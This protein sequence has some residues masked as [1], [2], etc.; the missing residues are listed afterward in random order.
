[1][2]G[3]IYSGRYQGNDE[4]LYPDKEES[5]KGKCVVEFCDDGSL[6]IA[7]E[8]DGDQLLWSGARKGEG[9]WEL[10][11]SHGN[12]SEAT[13]HQLT[14]E[15]NILEGTWKEGNEWGMWRIKLPINRNDHSVS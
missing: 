6:K 10:T 7:Y 3:T 13:L 15:S 8:D 14:P 12:K 9:H 2:S 5:L 11:E 1:M 4:S